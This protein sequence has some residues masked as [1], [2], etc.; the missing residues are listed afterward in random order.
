MATCAVE[1]IGLPEDEVRRPRGCGRA[2]LRAAPQPDPGRRR[3]PEGR[4][5]A[6]ASPRASPGSALGAV[7]TWGGPARVR[8]R[9]ECLL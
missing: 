8:G 7:G 9:G 3:R 4:L 6:P 2:S 5:S 1:V